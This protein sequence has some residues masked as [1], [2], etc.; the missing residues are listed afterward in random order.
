MIRERYHKDIQA[1]VKWDFV[2]G[3]KNQEIVETRGVHIR[4]LQRWR[5]S[6]EE[7]GE[8]LAPTIGQRGRPPKLDNLYVEQIQL[9]YKARPMAYLDEVCW[10]LYDE[11]DVQVCEATVWNALKKLNMSRKKTARVARERNHET[12]AMFYNRMG[13][14]R[15]EELVFLDESAANER[16]GKAD[17]NF[18]IIANHV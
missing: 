9:Y 11:Y 10:W 8:V 13:G 2:R 12:R 14:Y 5:M 15:K 4:A 3:V 16:T 1:I 18:V 6:W 7:C 17:E